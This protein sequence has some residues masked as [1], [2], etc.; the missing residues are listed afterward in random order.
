MFFCIVQPPQ[1]PPNE[2]IASN[3][4]RPWVEESIYPGSVRQQYMSHPPFFPPVHHQNVHLFPYPS[5]NGQ[6][7]TPSNYQGATYGYTAPY[8]VDPYR[9]GYPGAVGRPSTYAGQGSTY[10][11]HPST[12]ME[13]SN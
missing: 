9:D 11:S 13:K 12:S 6:L 4:N 5:S 2:A 3:G 8:N 7:Y 1:P 10:Y